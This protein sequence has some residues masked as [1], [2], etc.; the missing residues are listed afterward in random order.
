MSRQASNRSTR[1]ILSLVLLIVGIAL[2]AFVPGYIALLA[3]SGTQ[4]A[5]IGGTLLIVSVVGGMA[6]VI[7]ASALHE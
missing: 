2:L 5:H 3:F 7:V 4:T 6:S 1:R